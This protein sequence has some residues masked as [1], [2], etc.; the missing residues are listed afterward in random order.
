MLCA[1]PVKFKILSK[2]EHERGVE[3]VDWSFRHFADMQP[4]GWM[5]R[6][7]TL[8]ALA[9]QLARVGDDRCW[10]ILQAAED[11]AERVEGYEQKRRYARKN[12]EELWYAH[13]GVKHGDQ[14][15]QKMAHTD[16]ADAAA[17]ASW[18]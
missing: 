13:T 12:V 11:Y 3:L 8:E 2:P 18:S 5:P 4:L 14:S 9:M 10:D 15:P 17:L 7:G 16:D 6:F 1:G